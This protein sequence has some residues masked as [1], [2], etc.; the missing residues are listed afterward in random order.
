MRMPNWFYVFVA[1]GM[2]GLASLA[3]VQ[4]C[5][6][7]TFSVQG[8]VV[9]ETGNPIAN[10]AI[11]VWNNGAYERPAFDL[12][13]TT[14]ADGYF[15]T[16]SVFSYGCVSF[17][18]EVFAVGYEIKTLTFYPPANEGWS[19]ELPDEITVQLQPVSK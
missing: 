18:V 11:R 16:D 10:A 1:I 8:Y 6:G 19:N 5:M 2:L 12:I 3:C 14:D 17:Q 13:T 4:D 9:D 7:V 15:Q